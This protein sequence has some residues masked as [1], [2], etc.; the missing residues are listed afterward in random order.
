[1]TARMPVSGKIVRIKYRAS[2]KTR[3]LYPFRW[4]GHCPPPRALAD[5]VRTG[6]L[7]YEGNMQWWLTL[8]KRKAIVAVH[9]DNGFVDYDR[10]EIFFEGAEDCGE[11]HF[12]TLY[13]GARVAI[14]DVERFQIVEL[15]GARK[16]RLG[17]VWWKFQPS[18]TCAP[19]AKYRQRSRINKRKTKPHGSVP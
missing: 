16:T 2:H 19:R 13:I 17:D 14:G 15:T 12:A 18:P 4:R 3:K 6:A 5:S 1:M 11:H 8:L 9:P 7:T 10:R